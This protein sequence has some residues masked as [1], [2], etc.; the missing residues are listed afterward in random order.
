MY[1]KKVA[2]PLMLVGGIRSYEVAEALVD[3]GQGLYCVSRFRK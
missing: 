3:D 2:I 1:K